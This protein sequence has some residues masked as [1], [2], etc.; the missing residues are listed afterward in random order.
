[1]TNYA[2]TT[3]SVNGD[4]EGVLDALKTKIETIDDTKTIRTVD[5]VKRGNEF[6]GILIYDT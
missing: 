1:M 2:V 3:Y 4:V 5:V 6:S